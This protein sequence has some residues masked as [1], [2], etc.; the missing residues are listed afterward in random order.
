MVG[1][2]RAKLVSRT[3]KEITP[4][5]VKL[6][7]NGEGLFSGNKL[8]GKQMETVSL[9]QHGDGTLEWENKSILNTMEGEVVMFVG[10]GRGKT[11]GP[12]TIWGEGEAFCM[13]QAP[14]LA[15]LNGQRFRTEVTADQA[16]GE[17]QAK[18]S[19]KNPM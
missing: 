11:I 15:S 14:R 8:N 19:T 10:I 16:T 9:S 2:V 18:V 5:S 17:Y 4:H 3:I 6:E 7:V 12:T 1:E 13:T